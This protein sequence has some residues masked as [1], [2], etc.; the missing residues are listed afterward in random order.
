MRANSPLGFGIQYKVYKNLDS[1]ARFF[2]NYIPGSQKFHSVF[3]HIFHL[4]LLRCRCENSKQFTNFRPP[5][6]PRQ[7]RANSYKTLE[8]SVTNLSPP[9]G[10]TLCVRESHNVCTICANLNQNIVQ[11]RL[12]FPTKDRNAKIL[13]G[14]FNDQ[15]N[16][17]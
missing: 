11:T 4:N 5:Q 10:M 17:Y 15:F 16:G 12:V 7:S 9:Q 6:L 1:R 2:R 14:G 3:H 13:S 8:R